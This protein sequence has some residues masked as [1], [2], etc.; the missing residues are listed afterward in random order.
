VHSELHSWI[1]LRL[2]PGI[3]NVAC[4]N[5][6]EAFGTPERIFAAPAEKLAEIAGIS[7]KIIK[8]LHSSSKNPEIE[9]ELE[10]IAGTDI[11]IVAYNEPEY[12]QTL[13]NIYD[14]PP[15]VYIRGKLE[16]EDCSAIA[17]VGSRRASDYGLRAASDISRELARSGLTIVSGM[18]AGI[19]SAAHR[20]ALAS[21]G[22]TIAVLGCGVD[23][24]Y[25]AE[26]RRLYDE[27]ARTGAIVSEYTPG[28][29]P[30]S[31]HFPARNR[32]ISGLARGIL[33][34]EAGPKSGSL[35]TARLALEQGR[36]VFAVPGSIY[37][38]KTKGANQLI[39]SGAALVE[40]GRD[41]IEA[42]GISAVTRPERA[43]VPAPDELD[44]EARR[45]YDQLNAEPIHIDRLICETSL[46]SSAISS[47][48]LEL[49]LSG[50]VKQLPGKHF[51]KHST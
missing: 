36:D 20:G 23:V 12:P 11:R 50:Y 31:Y 29:E 24:C 28:T 37:S 39:R 35:I 32:I 44:N 3:G 10:K 6:L 1:A 49:E 38:Y 8:A 40:S 30:D 7:P 9:L 19:D 51:V 5:L 17:V 4:K 15:Y 43:V 2:T 16:P 34:V 42:L 22:R 47:A 27:I 14:P 26:N 13:K 46:P 33:V 25:P 48:L 18:A 41:I 45:V 21:K